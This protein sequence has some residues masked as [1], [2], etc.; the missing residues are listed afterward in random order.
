MKVVLSP[1][2][3]AEAG[4][5]ITLKSAAS[6]PPTA[7]NGVPLSASGALPVFLTVKTT[8]A[9]LPTVAV[10]K[11]TLPPSAMLTP[12]RS[13]AISGAAGGPPVSVMSKGLSSGSLL[14]M[15]IAAVLSPTL[16][17]A[18]RTVNAVVPFGPLT[19]AVGFAV[20][21]NIPASVPSWEI[22]SPVRSALPVFLM[23]K[24]RLLFAPTA[25]LPKLL[26]PPSVRL[27]LKGCSTA[28]SAARTVTRNVSVTVS[29]PSLTDTEI[30]A[31]PIWLASETTVTVRL[32]PLPPKKIFPSAT[33]A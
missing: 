29:N 17:G 33:S 5:E 28:I 12:E 25:T 8:S 21:V 10:T 14:A 11:P 31:V 26:V 15:W 18:N 4:G 13:T 9:G 2:P 7:T 24:F 32:A 22:V 20:T 3:T 23:M 27:L 30:V 16:V 19:G 1:A 6:V